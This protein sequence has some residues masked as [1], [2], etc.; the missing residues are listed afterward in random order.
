MLHYTSSLL[1]PNIASYL[2]EG[3]RDFPATVVF[4]EQHRIKVDH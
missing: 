4:G 3:E 2:D 1:L